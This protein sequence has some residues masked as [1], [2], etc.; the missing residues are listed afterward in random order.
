MSTH[1]IRRG[2]VLAACMT[3]LVT[4][5]TLAAVKPAAAAPLQCADLRLD[6]LTHGVPVFDVT[7]MAIA[8]DET[9]VMWV[10]AAGYRHFIGLSGAEPAPAARFDGTAWWGTINPILAD[11]ESIVGISWTATS[12]GYWM[13]TSAGRVFPFGDAGFFGDLEQL[14]V[15]PALP[16]K[17]GVATVAGD[18]YWLFAEDG[19]IFAFGAAG[20]HGSVPGALAGTGAQLAAP[21]VG[22]APSSTGEGYTMVGADG[23]MFAFGDAPFMGSLPGMGVTPD[24][25]IVDMIAS[26]GGYLQLGAD[27]GTFLFGNAQ[28]QG[29][30]PFGASCGRISYWPGVGAVSL[31][32]LDFLGAD[33]LATNDGY[34]LTDT[35]GWAYRFGEAVEVPRSGA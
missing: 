33:V 14:D 16:V 17:G 8:P 4:V 28:F 35:Q 15:V 13:F 7:D 25:P 32:G 24:E 5:A 22:M 12:Q 6:Q 11:G 23:G 1:T 34:I 21:I 19:G 27:G 18:G 29:S 3:L 9:V 30:I 26:P 10:G 20:F 31:S 2:T